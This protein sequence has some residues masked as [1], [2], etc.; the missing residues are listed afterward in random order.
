[1]QGLNYQLDKEPLIAIPI[2]SPEKSKQFLI[3]N[4]VNKILEIKNKDINGDITSIEL[5]IDHIVYKL[6]DLTYD[7][8][9]VI[10]PLTSIT[11]EEY[12]L[13]ID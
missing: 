10:D 4:L 11:R 13:E 8:V 5:K 3:K 1:M 6:Y 12:E 7:E 9:F 2:A